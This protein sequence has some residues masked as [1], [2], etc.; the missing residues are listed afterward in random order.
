MTGWLSR[1]RDLLILLLG[2]LAY[3]V[4]IALLAFGTGFMVG[5]ERGVA[6]TYGSDFTAKLAMV[7]KHHCANC[8]DTF[9]SEVWTYC[10]ECGHKVRQ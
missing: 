3:A 10:P 4:S 9:Y 1:R 5:M 2:S 7:E 8:G 6:K